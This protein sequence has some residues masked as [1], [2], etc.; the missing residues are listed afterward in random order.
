MMPSAPMPT[1]VATGMRRPRMHGTPSICL[2]SKVI[3]VNLTRTSCAWGKGPY[4]HRLRRGDFA[5]HADYIHFYPINHGHV[6][7]VLRRMVRLAAYPEDWTAVPE[8]KRPL[9]RTVTK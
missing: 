6:V 9:R 3:R 1:T 8:T 7:F 5:R 4:R 2:G